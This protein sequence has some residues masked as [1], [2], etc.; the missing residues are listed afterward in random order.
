MPVK[1]NEVTELLA[2]TK[3]QTRKERSKLD[4]QCARIED[5]VGALQSVVVQLAFWVD[6]PPKGGY[7]NVEAGRTTE[8]WKVLGR[9]YASLV[10]ARSIA[11]DMDGVEL[12]LQQVV[13]SPKAT[14][15]AVLHR[16]ESHI[17]KLPDVTQSLRSAEVDAMGAF[18]DL[19]PA[20]FKPIVHRHMETLATGITVLTSILDSGAALEKGDSHV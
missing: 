2:Q 8:P 9:C 6:P 13:S 1:S 14:A 18:C 20:T 7:Y 3:E 16:L 10:T 19:D 11:A 4:D 17:A 15:E 5:T 12:L